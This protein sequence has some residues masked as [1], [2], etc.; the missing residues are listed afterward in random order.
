[1][2]LGT[3]A[4]RPVLGEHDKL[5]GLPV[6]GAPPQ[7]LGH[8]GF[9]SD[10]L[11]LLRYMS[12]TE[13]H[14]YAFSVAANAILSLFPFIV[15]M[16]TIARNV[17]HSDAMESAIADMIR[18][19]LPTGQ[20]FVTKN[21]E[22]VAHARSRVQIASVVMLLISTTGVFLPLEVALNRVWGVTKNRSYIMNQLVALCL[23]IGIGMVA[24]MSVALT[25]AQQ[26]IL[27]VLFFGHVENVVYGFISHWVLQIS[28]AL[29]SVVLFFLIYWVLP[30]RK[31]PVRA[32]L[33]TAVVI[34][35]AWEGAK[36]L[37]IAALPWMDL[38][39]VYGPFSVSVSLML[40]AFVT[41]LLLL[42]GAHYSATRHALRAA[43][44][45]D[46]ERAKEEAKE[47]KAATV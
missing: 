1:M 7:R 45:A 37:Y 13:V 39:S 27:K 25:A 8:A 18:Y 4:F 15:M 23:A 12:Q 35:L 21:M 20:Q 19:F 31:L 26:S 38:H 36:M 17:F 28:A 46:L 9:A 5:A 34:G 22:I 6:Q 47:E 29:A 41:G 40:W 14:T 10:I 43:Y 2:S 42:A 30:N 16:F 44:L 32:V 24:L 3:S 11:G 33:P